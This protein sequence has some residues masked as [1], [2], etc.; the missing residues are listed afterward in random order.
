MVKLPL[1]VGI[2][3]VQVMLAEYLGGSSSIAWKAFVAKIESGCM[4]Q[5]RGK[6]TNTKDWV[7][8]VCAFRGDTVRWRVQFSQ[9]V[10]VMMSYF[11]V[12]F[13]FIDIIPAIMSV[14]TTI[15]ALAI[16]VLLPFPISC[17]MFV[18]MTNSL[19]GSFLA[20]ITD[21]HRDI[22]IPFVEATRAGGAQRTVPSSG[23]GWGR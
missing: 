4:S 1:K 6:Q 18:W 23:C 21:V 17:A 20:G 7:D 3:G 14:C 12:S 15:N 13:R 8:Q 5:I 9:Y 19:G 11:I 10:A 22:G 16:L 2:Q